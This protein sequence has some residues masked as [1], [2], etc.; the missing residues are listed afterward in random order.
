MSSDPWA[1]S[2]FNRVGT[3]GS[4]MF[5]RPPRIADCTLRDGEQQ[6]GV[7]FSRQDKVELA[8]MI[9]AAGVNE[10]EAGTPAVSAEDRLALEE[11]VALKLPATVSAVAR[12]RRDDID[13]VASTG[14]WGVRISLPISQRQ[15]AVKLHLG[16]DEYLQQALELSAYARERGLHVIFSPYD[17]TR[18]DVHLLG[19]LL[20]L[21]RR[22]Q[23]V[24]RVRL[25]DTTGAAT[26]GAIRHLTA[27]M[28]E[29]GGGIP[30][31]VH[32][33]ND[34]GLATANTI[35]GAAAGAAYLS[36]TVNGI[37]ERSGN[38]ALEEVVTALKVL[39]G[40]DVGVRT[41]FL[42]ALSAEVQRRANVPLQPHKAVV[43][44]N[45]FAHESGMVVA[46]I[47]AD[48]FTSECYPPELVGQK[49]S[50]VL[51]KLSGGASVE[52][53][54]REMGIGPD[55]E[56]V[57]TLLGLVKAEAI[58]LGRGLTDEEFRTLVVRQ[59]AAAREGAAPQ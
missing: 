35:A 19:R 8:R 27:F 37:G 17:T 9:A 15:R 58:R 3:E 6:A 43:G 59:A 7:A 51:G 20:D 40:V 54:L 12:A 41:Q 26:T 53:K 18:S 47:L 11:I 44:R 23:C 56:L 13:L 29:A 14:A 1:V 36:V 48:P 49:R 39:Y 2:P 38:A 31:E 33:H 10:I 55:R 57:R 4:P 25:V 5:S 16:D 32:V 28:L 52:Y 46:G 42:Q 22:E 45:S 30:I 24:D 50:I 34:L 21:F